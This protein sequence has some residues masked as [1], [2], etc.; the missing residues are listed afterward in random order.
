MDLELRGH[1]DPHRPALSLPIGNAGTPA[2]VSPVEPI[3]RLT[4]LSVLASLIL[5][6]CQA[7]PAPAPTERGAGAEG[8]A[9]PAERPAPSFDGWTIRVS[10]DP[11]SVGPLKLA[12]GPLTSAPETDSHP[13]VQHDVKFINRGDRLVRFEDTRTSGFIRSAGRPVLLVADEGCGYEKR[14]KRVKPG[15][16]L[17]YLDA[18]TIRAGSSARR[19]ITLFKDL[20]G[21][22]PL[23]AG[24]YRWNK[25]IRFRV[26]PPDAP[27]RTATIRLTYELSPAGG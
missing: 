24:T 18:F 10:L 16:C 19:T 2:G 14:A 22:E 20:R 9:S 27:V 3:M 1:R 25:V 6:G 15:A 8:G 26:G 11:D 23:A 21:M 17:L 12:V 7:Q 13:W 5:A 4:A